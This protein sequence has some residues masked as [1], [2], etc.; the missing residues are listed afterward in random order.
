MGSERDDTMNLAAKFLGFGLL[1]L[2]FTLITSSA[3]ATSPDGRCDGISGGLGKDA[4]RVSAARS[5]SRLEAVGKITVAKPAG[6]ELV[7]A[8]E[9]GLSAPYLQRVLDCQRARE[10]GLLGVD[11]AVASVGEA[12][13][14]FLVRVEAPTID[15]ARKV[16]ASAANLVSR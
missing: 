16:Q 6:S 7:V 14:A 10:G 9:A 8:A 15:D 5:V 13:G 2:G 3:Q 12:R 11:G 1:S 4:L